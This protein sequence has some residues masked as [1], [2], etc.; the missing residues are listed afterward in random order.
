V[1]SHIAQ[2]TSIIGPTPHSATGGRHYYMYD[3]DDVAL[4]LG[5][6][7]TSWYVRQRIMSGG[8]DQPLV[9][10]LVPSA[11]SAAR[12]MAFIAD[13]Q[14]TTLA[15]VHPS[16]LRDETAA[17]FGR[18]VFGTLEGASGTGS[19]SNPETGFTGAS[20]PNQTGGF[21]Y[22]RNRWYDPQSG[23]FLTQD[24]I[25]LAGGVNLYAYA[26]NNPVSFSDPFGL[27]PCLA[28]GNCTQSD[29]G[30]DGLVDPNS[31]G[32]VQSTLFDPSAFIGTVA[33][34]IR[35]L[36]RGGV[37]ALAEGGAAEAG[38]FTTKIAAR[39]ALAGMGLPEAQGAAVNR[40][41]GR[42]TSKTTIGITQGEG[43]NVTVTLTRAGRD[44]KQ[45]MESV[46]SPDGTKAVVQK[47]VNAR[48]VVEHLDPK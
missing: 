26:G 30:S 39:K 8:L 19:S 18:N 48:G 2:G 4:V 3:G 1:I 32:N 42:A 10:R 47:G 37:A 33:S 6:S 43:G 44:G 17:Y 24:P 46:V 9:T 29:G 22:L 14:G 11:G 23:R 27:S 15:A 41:I 7:G 31:V 13:R 12:N 34:G 21:T 5:R 16:G 40:A 36:F 28:Y 38:A 35:G 45:V 20:T 25:G